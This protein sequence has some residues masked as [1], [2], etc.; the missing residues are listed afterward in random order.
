[1]RGGKFEGELLPI[2]ISIPV[3][4]WYPV[5]A[6]P[7]SADNSGSSIGRRELTEIEGRSAVGL[8]PTHKAAVRAKAEPGVRLWFPAPAFWLTSPLIGRP[9]GNRAQRNSRKRSPAGAAT[10]FPQTR[11]KIHRILTLFSPNSLE[12]GYC[13]CYKCFPIT[14]GLTM[15]S[16]VSAYSASLRC[17]FAPFLLSLWRSSFPDAVCHRASRLWAPSPAR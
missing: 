16:S 3:A 10:D 12:S 4:G 5:H 9:S 14:G 11:K 15:R 13:L 17:V 2:R 1:M 7:A 6:T 8:D